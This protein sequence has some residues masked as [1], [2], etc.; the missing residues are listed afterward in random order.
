MKKLLLTFITLF[1]LSSLL[2]CSS[3]NKERLTYGTLYHESSVEVDT[4]AVYSKKE[5]ENFFLATYGDETCG[6]WTYF[7]RVLDHLAKYDHFLSYKLKND[8]IDDR[9]NEFG[10][11]N[12]NDPAFYIIAN[13]KIVRREFY[14]DNS[15]Y[16]TDE[17]V[18]LDLIK[19]T[20]DLPYMYLINEEQIQ[21]EVVDKDGI[22]YYS[23]MTCP[24]CSYCTPNVLMPYFKKIKEPTDKVYVFDMDP[25]RKEDKEKYQQFKDDHF[26]SNKNNTDF[27]YN[28]GYVPTFQYYK[29]GALYDMAVYF[30]DEVTDG[31]ITTSY[32]DEERLSH[33]HYADKLTKKVL[34]GTRLEVYEISSSGSW[35]NS[36]VHSS[37]YKPFIEAFFDCYF[38]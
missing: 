32:Y 16:F 23:R 33:I 9:L 35:L 34:T 31:L 15:S 3:G 24:D 30:N 18:L 11:K 14:V 17:N 8:Q 4:D 36:E 37:Y 38:K 22:I 28:T 10:I 13:K 20:I 7:S 27:G 12:S 2:G 1:S 29:D 6:C 5:S 21:T 19:E 26:L 25:I